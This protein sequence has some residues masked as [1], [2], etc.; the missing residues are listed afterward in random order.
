MLEN[1]DNATIR[2][3]IHLQNLFDIFHE[4]VILSIIE[5]AIDYFLDDSAT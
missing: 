4:F 3:S 2:D 1:P 5:E